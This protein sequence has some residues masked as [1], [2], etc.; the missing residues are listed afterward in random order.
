[1]QFTKL[2][3]SILDSTIW[4]EPLETKVVWITMLAMCDRNGEVHASI[5]GLAKRAGVTIP[6]C[7]AALSCLESPDE[8]SRTKDHDGRRIEEIDGGWALLN[9]A[10]YRQ[11]L[12]AE[13]RREYNRRK[14]AEYR[15]N[16]K[17]DV[18]DMS[19]TVNHNKQSPHSTEAE[20]DTESAA[21]SSRVRAGEAARAADGFAETKTTAGHM[22]EIEKRVQSLRPG[23]R[24]PLT[25]AEQQALR[26]NARCLDGMADDDWTLIA[27]YLHAKLPDGSPGWQPRSRT[28]FLESISD[29]FTYATEWRRK[30]EARRPTATTAPPLKKFVPV[31]GDT[32][33]EVFGEKRK[34]T[35]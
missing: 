35:G 15:A 5:P 29:V 19:M 20:A 7:N 27:D 32:L 30:Q 14:Q 18:N 1:M 13:E 3:N 23:W 11:L 4:Q 6:Q 16:R 31:D 24:I 33:A 28:K 34:A 12:S 2:F 9:H 22:L 17:K 25:Y 21:R 10:K 26:D 8:Y